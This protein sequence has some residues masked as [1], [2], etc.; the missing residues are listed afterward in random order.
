MDG[1]AFKT[2]LAAVIMKALCLINWNVK[3]KILNAYTLLCIS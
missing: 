1:E 2:R 3:L